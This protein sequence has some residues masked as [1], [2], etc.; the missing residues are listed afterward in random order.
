MINFFNKIKKT[1]NCWNW[2]GAN[3]GHGYGYFR[4]PKKPHYAHR[5]SWMLHFGKIPEGMCVLHKC[6]N[7]KCVNPKHLFIGTQQDN[8]LDCVK[9]RRWHSFPG[10]NHKLAKLK[11]KD[12]FT[13]KNLYRKENYSQYEIA[14]LFGVS[15]ANVWRILH[16]V[17]WKHVT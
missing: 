14:K 16:N 17:A 9:K 4:F 3:A 1:K 7:R 12:I 13:I 15:Q 6:D 11:N 5:V 2:T 8:V 10:E